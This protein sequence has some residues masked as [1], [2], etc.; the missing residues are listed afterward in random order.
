[1]SELCLFIPPNLGLTKSELFATAIKLGHTSQEM[2]LRFSL[3]YIDEMKK[4]HKSKNYTKPKTD[5]LTQ[6]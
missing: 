3:I 6:Q 1:M 4:L 2:Q 5:L